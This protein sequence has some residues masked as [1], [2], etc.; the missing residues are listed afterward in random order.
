MTWHIDTPP[1]E[2][3]LKKGRNKSFLC[4]LFHFFACIYVIYVAEFITVSFHYLFRTFFACAYILKILV[5]NSMIFEIV[6]MTISTKIHCSQWPWM[7]TV[8]WRRPCTSSSS[9]IN[10]HLLV[11]RAKLSAIFVSLLAMPILG[12][13]PEIECMRLIWFNLCF[14]QEHRC[15]GG[16]FKWCKYIN[17]F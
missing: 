11:L 12:E 2:N 16:V 7:L 4:K 3:C 6:N 9:C 1:P 17:V 15:R 5:S 8:G 14:L 10:L 13:I